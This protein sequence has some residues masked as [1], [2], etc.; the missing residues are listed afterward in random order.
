LGTFNTAISSA[1]LQEI[2]PACST[3]QSIGNG[4]S[5]TSSFGVGNYAAGSVKV[6]KRFSHGLQFLASYVWSHALANGNTPLSGDTSIL[7]Q[8]NYSSSYTSASWDIRHSFTTAF[9]YELP[10]GR[11]K[12]V[13]GS[14]NRAADLVAGGWQINGILTLRTGDA[15]T[16]SG[17][18]CHGVWSKCMP[19]YVQGFSGNGN[20][21]P[22]GGRTPNE[23]FDTGNYT[24]AYSNQ[25]LGIAT[26]GD[27]GLQ[28]LTGPSTKTLDFSIFKNFK[29][30]EKFNLQFRGEAINVGNMTVFSNPDANLGDSKA[31]GGNGNFGVITSS[32]AGTERHLQF[33]LRFWF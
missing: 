31:Y 16:M 23:W 20:A 26:G 12:R 17:T 29:L 1:N 13:G 24:A 2:Q 9:N 32:V 8:T 7:D 11:G 22:A 4:L 3:C 28:T 27:V 33:S 5:M 10:F 18:S 30:T 25:P 15:Y 21:A 19:D 6:E 14:M